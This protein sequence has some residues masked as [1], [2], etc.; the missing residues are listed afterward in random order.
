MVAYGAERK[1]A[2]N[3]CLTFLTN[4]KRDVE[5]IT[6]AE[7]QLRAAPLIHHS[8]REEADGKVEGGPPR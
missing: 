4:V 3:E 1:R 8:R 5:L 7:A 2:N 6:G